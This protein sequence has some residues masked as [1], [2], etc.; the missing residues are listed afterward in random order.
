VI[1]HCAV[2]PALAKDVEHR[3]AELND[4]IAAD[5]RLGTQFRIG[6]S[7]VTPT[8]TLEAGST[9]SWFE[10]V[11][12]TEIRPLLEEYWFDAPDEAQKACARLLQS[13]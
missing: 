2:D 13:W 5:A 3:I 6:H 8:H 1:K 12:E 7:Y 9:K 11:I 4:R 10:Q